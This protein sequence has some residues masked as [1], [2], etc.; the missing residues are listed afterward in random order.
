MESSHC[1]TY[2][3]RADIAG[4]GSKALAAETYDAT[5]QQ[6]D[7]SQVEQNSRRELALEKE[8][9]QNKP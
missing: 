8:K 5:C 4:T 9:V 2:R 6:D 1:R 7:V 3:S